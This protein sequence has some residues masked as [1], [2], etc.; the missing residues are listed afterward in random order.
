MHLAAPGVRHGAERAQFL[1]EGVAGACQ[2]PI[3][4]SRCLEERRAGLCQLSG[5]L[6]EFPVIPE[7]QR[8]DCT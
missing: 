8:G 2:M 6:S 4:F 5:S 7:S 1:L 3:P